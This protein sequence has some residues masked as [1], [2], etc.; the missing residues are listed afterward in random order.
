MDTS[1]GTGGKGGT[2]QHQGVKI[3]V[4]SKDNNNKDDSRE[5]VDIKKVT[6]DEKKVVT[7]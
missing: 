1:K 2:S 5:A 7:G 3:A 6:F 4:E